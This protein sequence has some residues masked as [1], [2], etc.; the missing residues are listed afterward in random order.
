MSLVSAHPKTALF[1]AAGIGAAAVLIVGL[2][3]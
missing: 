3:I 2:V 1:I